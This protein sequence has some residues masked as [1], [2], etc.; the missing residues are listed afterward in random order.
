MLENK[1]DLIFIGVLNFFGLK[2]TSIKPCSN[3]AN[4]YHISLPKWH[5]I[6]INLHG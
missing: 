6:F 1:T 5:M 2:T 3:L 4:L